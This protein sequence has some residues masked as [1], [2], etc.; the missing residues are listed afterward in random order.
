MHENR[1]RLPRYAFATLCL[2]LAGCA[3]SAGKVTVPLTATQQILL[4]EAIERSL[5]GLVWPDVKGKS[6]VVHSASP[7]EATV[8]PGRANDDYL[9][10][11]VERRLLLN[12]ARIVEDDAAAD[13]VLLALAG[14]TGLNRSAR[15]LGIL[16]AG[17][18]FIPVLLPEIVLYKSLREDG[19]AKT[20]ILLSNAKAGGVVH[21]SG[22]AAGK[23][24]A[25]SRVLLFFFRKRETDTSLKPPLEEQEASLGS[26]TN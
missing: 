12:G 8:V 9:R 21:Q 5:D 7:G 4:T 10:S 15:L 18:G 3:I 23:T 6:V 17:G 22:P 13:Y 16:G 25:R 24:Y 26:T 19:F 1:T 20:E 14:A 2:A 11:S